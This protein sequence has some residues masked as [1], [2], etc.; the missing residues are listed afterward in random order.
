MSWRYGLFGSHSFLVSFL[1]IDHTPSRTEGN[2]SEANIGTIDRR[3]I[4]DSRMQDGT[5]CYFST[6]YRSGPRASLIGIAEANQVRNGPVFV[7]DISGMYRLRGTKIDVFNYLACLCR[8]HA[9]PFPSH[10][11]SPACGKRSLYTARF[12][13]GEPEL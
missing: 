5:Y 11:P 13:L 9:R 4:G 7:L 2:R 12:R 6:G 8:V 10:V 3:V 1:Q